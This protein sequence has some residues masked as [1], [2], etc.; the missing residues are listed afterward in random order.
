MFWLTI[1]PVTTAL[2]EQ[3]VRRHDPALHI[4]AALWVTL[5][6]GIIYLAA[7]LIFR[8]AKPD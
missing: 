6:D 8:P 2:A 7:I 1:L 5:M 3:L 4:L